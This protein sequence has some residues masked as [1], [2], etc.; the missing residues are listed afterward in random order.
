MQPA[1]HS[2]PVGSTRVE[3]KRRSNRQLLDRMVADGVQPTREL[4]SM[5][6]SARPMYGASADPF[7]LWQPLGVTGFVLD[8]NLAFRKTIDTNDSF[9]NSN[10]SLQ[11]NWEPTGWVGTSYTRPSMLFDGLNDY[12]LCSTSMASTLVGGSDTPFT[13]FLVGQHLDVTTADRV[14]I[15]MF[16]T[17]STSP[18]WDIYAH[19]ATS[20]YGSLKKDNVPTSTVLL[21]G[22]PDTSKRVID[23]I[24]SGTNLD[25]RVAGSSIISATQNVGALTVDCMALG[26]SY[27]NAAPGNWGNYRLARV[28]GFTGALGA[29][30]RD[31]VYSVL[32]SMYL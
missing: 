25:V 19:P 16:S 7:Y 12:L 32:S 28:I 26:A 3:R 4:M 10:Q 31:Y 24:H 6:L 11:P 13:L 22:T 27:A 18:V 29:P 23:A 20:Q 30:D 2:R 1:F 15:G 17:T 21:G 9:T 14:M 5:V 8:I